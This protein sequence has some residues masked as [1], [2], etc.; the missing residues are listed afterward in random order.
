M[1]YICLGYYDPA[2][3]AAW[4]EEQQNAMF[5]EYASAAPIEKQYFQSCEVTDVEG[6]SRRVRRFVGRLRCR[7]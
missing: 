4:T 1:K 3:Q 6:S 2:S 5:D 7:G